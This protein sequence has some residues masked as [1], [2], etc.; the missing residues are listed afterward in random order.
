MTTDTH[1]DRLA[2]LEER[3]ARA[4]LAATRAGLF[5]SALRLPAHARAEREIRAAADEALERTGLSGWAD[6]P[7]CR[8]GP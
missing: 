8:S 2:E 3:L 1:T 6:R 5:S 7:A 4:E